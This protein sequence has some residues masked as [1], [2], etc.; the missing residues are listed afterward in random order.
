MNG[1]THGQKAGSSLGDL[2]F[3]LKKLRYFTSSVNYYT[4]LSREAELLN[5]A[6]QGGDAIA[7]RQ[8]GKQIVHVQTGS[9]GEVQLIM[10]GTVSLEEQSSHNYPGG[11][12]E[13][14]PWRTFSGRTC[15]Q[16]RGRP[17]HPAE[18]D[19]VEALTGLCPCQHHCHSELHSSSELPPLLPVLELLTVLLAS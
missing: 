4:E 18:P 2:S 17:C 11:G 14:K 13:G 19:V 8:T 7:C 10:V 1:Q 5:A 16:A 6:K 15:C 12:G 9:K 3:Q